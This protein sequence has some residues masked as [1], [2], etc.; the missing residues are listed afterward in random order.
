M[1]ETLPFI[2]ICFLL[3]NTG[4][5]EFTGLEI[6][7]PVWILLFNEA[8]SFLWNIKLSKEQREKHFFP[9]STHQTQMLKILF[10]TTVFQRS[11]Y[12]DKGK[13]LTNTNHRFLTIY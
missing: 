13:L 8:C 12:T 1:L 9:I 11:M 6:P 4:T 2:R 5:E 10:C 7:G 3:K